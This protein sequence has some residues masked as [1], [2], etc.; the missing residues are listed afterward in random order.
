MAF[1]ETPRFPECVSL[2]AL[3]KPRYKSNVIMLA[4]GA[5]RANIEWANGLHSFDFTH[6]AMD[7]TQHDSILNF[8][9]AI[10]GRGNQFR[11]KDYS[12][13]STDI[14]TGILVPISAGRVVGTVGAGY[15]VIGYVVAKLYSSGA[16]A[17]Y[18]LLQKLVSG[19]VF[20]RNGSPITIG[21]GPGS[22][23]AIDTTTGQVNFVPDQTRGISAHAVGAAHQLTVST[24]F[25]PNFVI[26]QRVYIT[27]VTGTAA[28]TLNNLSHAITNVAGAVLTI[29][30][31]TTGLTATGGTAEFFP[32]VTDTLRVV[33][34]FDVPCR[35]SS[36]E[37]AFEIFEKTGTTL[38]YRWSGIN[39]EEERIDLA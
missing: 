15:G 36:D 33:T 4:S 11:V 20:Y 28:T 14:D 34:E 16:L 10:Q 30:T 5:K 27:G 31:A 13:F 39:L 21:G 22:I 23:V 35:F 24:A 6:G 8:F 7:Q 25:S 26:G 38:L 9:H 2:G 3:V 37:A 29:S 19:T 18:R 12:D 17:T 32:Q 1:L